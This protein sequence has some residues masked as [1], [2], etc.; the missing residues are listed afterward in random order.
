M[1]EEQ[2]IGKADGLEVGEPRARL[3]T[4]ALEEKAAGVTVQVQLSLH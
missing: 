2:E 3:M 1:R 4:E